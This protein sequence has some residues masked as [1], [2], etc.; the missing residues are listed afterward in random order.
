MR[1]VV[2]DGDV[3]YP[4]TSGKRLRTLNLML[5][6]ADRHHITYLARVT[7]P[8]A[9]TEP[10]RRFL[11]ARGI[12]VQLV[13]DPLPRKSGAAFYGRLLANLASPLPYSVASHQSAAMRQA[14]NALAA[15]E[16]VDLWQCEWSGY[17]P[18]L[19]DQRR[20][21]RLLMA[22]NVDALIWQ[23]YYETERRWVRRR[24]LRE[25]WRKTVKFEQAAFHQ[26]ARVVA[27]SDA[28]AALMADQFGVTH[29]DVVENGIDCDWL[30]HAT[31]SRKAN[32]YLFLGALDWRPNQDA[33]RRLLDELVPQ[34]ARLQPA[35]RLL[36]VGRKPPPWLVQRA[37]RTAHVQL[38]ADVPD[39]RPFLAESS[40]M[41][42]PLRI[43]GGSRLKILEAL[44]AG[45]PVV[46]T[47]VGAEGLRLVAGQHFLEANSDDDLARET[48]RCLNEPDWALNLAAAGKRLVQQEYDWPILADRLHQ[49][50]MSFA[51]TAGVQLSRVVAEE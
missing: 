6:L 46:S 37:A 45:L 32:Q 4:P 10:A 2:V 50:W 49:I 21:R 19:Q 24:F 35:A 27:V 34:I 22:H 25:Q 9:P 40:V 23:R 30:A 12:D 16:R 3:S 38:L 14:V 18:A 20:D 39:V 26:A 7:D 17:L 42:V 51:A 28:D 33:V 41:I 13:H 29:V 31:G 8:E 47:T 15:R 43:G 48:V 36:I 1:V 44:A 5:H 11:A